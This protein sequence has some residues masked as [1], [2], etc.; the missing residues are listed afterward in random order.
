MLLKF[1]RKITIYNRIYVLL[2]GLNLTALNGSKSIVKSIEASWQ[3]KSFSLNSSVNWSEINDQILVAS[4]FKSQIRTIFYQLVKQMLTDD[5]KLKFNPKTLKLLTAYFTQDELTTMIK[6]EPKAKISVCI[7]F[8]FF[9]FEQSLLFL[10]YIYFQQ[11]DDEKIAKRIFKRIK[12]NSQL[13]KKFTE[14]DFPY[15]DYI[16]Q[17]MDK[18]IST[19]IP[20]SS[21]LLSELKQNSNINT[22]E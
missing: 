22:Y 16:N 21:K 3:D 9:N 15:N 1:Y 11:I 18:I 2:Y 20:E 13:I 12:I 5:A 8:D 10:Q 4:L 19:I 6:S 14:I 17:H 7:I